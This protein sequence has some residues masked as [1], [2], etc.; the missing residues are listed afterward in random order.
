MRNAIKIK[1]QKVLYEL[2]K[3]V[4]LGKFHDKEL[5]GTVQTLSKLSEW[6]TRRNGAKPKSKMRSGR[7]TC[8]LT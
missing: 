8:P 5:S 6:P 7:P 1:V 4:T 2:V 3:E